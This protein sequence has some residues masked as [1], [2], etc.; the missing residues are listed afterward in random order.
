MAIEFFH[1]LVP[2]LAASDVVLTLEPNAPAYG[3]DYLTHYSDAVALSE[4]IASPWVQPQ[5]D[6]GCMTMVGED[7]VDALTARS[8]AHV[9]ISVP[10]L[11]PP[12][13]PVDHAALE[14]ALEER[15]YDGWIV[16]EM[17]QATRD[18]LDAAI[19]SAHWLTRTYATTGRGH[20]AH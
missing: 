3:A 19:G 2:E 5:V 4:A 7:P 10:D 9:H 15:R 11:L 16:L 8:P 6:T 18:P 13:G 20:A 1:G 12:P 17:L 14:R